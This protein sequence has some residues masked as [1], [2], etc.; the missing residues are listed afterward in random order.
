MALFERSLALR[1]A[2]KAGGGMALFSPRPLLVAGGFWLAAADG[3]R[4]GKEGLDEMTLADASTGRERAFF[5][6]VSAPAVCLA[7][8]FSI[9]AS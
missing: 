4:S 2:A 9:G 8:S 1:L 7:L 6:R 3:S 5:K